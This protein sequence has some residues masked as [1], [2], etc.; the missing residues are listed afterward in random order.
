MHKPKIL[1][2]TGDGINCERETARA[3]DAAGGEAKILHINDVLQSPKNLENFQA[4]AL[5]GG[6]SFGDDLGSGQILALKLAHG[7]GDNLR[8]FVQAKKP[9][10]GICNGFQ[11]LVKLGLLPQPF[12]KRSLALGRNIQNQF[13]NRWVALEVEERSP[14][15]WTKT[16]AKWQKNGLDPV[17]LPIRHGEGR[18]VFTVGEEEV[19]HQA[20]NEAGQV[21]LRYT[22]NVNGSYARIAGLC[23][24]SGLIFGLMPHPE[25]AV[26]KLQYPRSGATIVAGEDPMQE[27]IGLQMFKDCIHYLAEN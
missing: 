11:A 22:T 5:P 20:L 16:F 1:V 9:V 17:E 23:D 10:I 6:F 3:F 8:Q 4:L 15:I 21:P 27:G 18:I 12:A 14:C 25:A 13:I 24:P 7:L 19:L 26:L 2:L